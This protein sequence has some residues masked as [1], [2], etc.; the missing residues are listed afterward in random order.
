MWSRQANYSINLNPKLSL[1][2]C[3]KYQIKSVE[4]FSFLDYLLL[5]V[6]TSRSRFLVKELQ[7]AETLCECL[8]CHRSWA[9]DEMRRFG[10]VWGE[11]FF[12][13]ENNN[14]QLKRGKL[15]LYIFLIFCEKEKI[16]YIEAFCLFSLPF[17]SEIFTYKMRLCICLSEKVY[18]IERRVAKICRYM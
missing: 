10:V 7:K 8:Y 3:Q 2:K 5:R 12:G 13:K 6:F 1:N 4:R 11:S 18:F 16:E 14:S 17:S 9:G 15:S